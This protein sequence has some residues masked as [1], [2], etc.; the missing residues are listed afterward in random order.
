MGKLGI[1]VNLKD[2]KYFI[3]VLGDA[4]GVANIENAVWGAFD[5]A[6]TI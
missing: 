3:H 4:K 6:R 1:T 2:S 5:L